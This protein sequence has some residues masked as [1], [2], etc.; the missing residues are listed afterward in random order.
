MFGCETRYAEIRS[1]LPSSTSDGGWLLDGCS[2]VY[3]HTDERFGLHPAPPSTN[4]NHNE[5]QGV[6]HGVHMYVP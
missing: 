3:V 1:P 2:L 5:S 4:P 6:Y